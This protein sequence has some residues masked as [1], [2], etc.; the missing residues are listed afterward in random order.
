[1]MGNKWIRSAYALL[2]GAV[3]AAAGMLAIAPAAHA[4]ALTDYAENKIIDA[5]IRGQTVSFPATWYIGLDTATCNDAGG[6]TEVTGGSYARVSVTANMTQWAGTQSAGSTTTSS[7]TGGTTSNNNVVTFPTPSAG[8][9]TVVSVRWWDASTSGNA[10]IC[11][12][13]TTTKTI[14]SGD[15]VSFPAGTL[16]FQIDN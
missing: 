2:A 1:M 13:L 10:W 8:W 5:A 3:M 7:G 14:N 11:T 12:A 15:A 9:G 4:A 6:G 16:T